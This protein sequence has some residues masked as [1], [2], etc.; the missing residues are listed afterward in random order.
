MK[1]I[2]PDRIYSKYMEDIVLTC[3]KRKNFQLLT[4]GISMKPLLLPGDIVSIKK[5]NFLSVK[6]NDIILVH[7]K[8]ASFIHRVIFKTNKFVI[9]K[10][11]ANFETDG[12]IFN[13]NILGKIYSIKRNNKDIKLNDIYFYYSSIF[14]QE[15]VKI[16]RW[17]EKETVDFLFLKGLPLF[18]YIKRKFPE[19][20]F[21]DLDLLIAPNSQDSVRRILQKLG[22]T[23]ENSEAYFFYNKFLNKRMKGIEYFKQIGPIK[24]RLD[25]HFEII[26]PTN[27]VALPI[28]NFA[29]DIRRITDFFICGKQF[30]SVKGETY[31]ILGD[32]NLLLFLL[33]H[34]YSHNW[35]GASRLE[36][37]AAVEKKMEKRINWV[38]IFEKAKEYKIINFLIPG[39]YL[40]S[41]YYNIREPYLL[42]KKNYPNETDYTFKIY[43]AFYSDNN[44]FCSQKTSIFTRYKKALI[45]LLLY[46]EIL[47]KKILMTFH[48]KL[49]GHFIYFS[50][51]NIYCLF[52]LIFSFR[53]PIQVQNNLFISR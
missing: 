7:K 51:Y 8:N 17:F 4:K 13:K 25:I 16:K 11:D 47:Y 32:N 31:P 41:K 2:S 45:I 15:A 12:K 10:G 48:P 22:Y 36:F 43:T 19:R 27:R 44:F 6:V 37:I 29:K 21:C 42:L 14:L 35:Q 23:A 33:L 49:L 24:V 9:T 52:K 38:S 46:D 34:F 5:I 1:I 28:G 20:F 50:L 39:V 3:F 26:F 18:F 40:L 30:I 53:R